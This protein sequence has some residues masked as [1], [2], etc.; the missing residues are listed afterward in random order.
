MNLAANTLKTLK[1][2]PNQKDDGPLLKKQRVDSGSD[3]TNYPTDI[4]NHNYIDDREDGNFDLW[5]KSTTY[6]KY[7]PSSISRPIVIGNAQM[8][9]N[10]A[11]ITSVDQSINLEAIAEK[12]LV[13]ITRVLASAVTSTTKQETD[14]A[15]LLLYELRKDEIKRREAE[16]GKKAK[17]EED[18]KAA[19]KEERER[20]AKEKQEGKERKA[21][22]EK[23]EYERKVKAK[24]EERERKEQ[25]EKE[26]YKR[27]VKAKQE[28]NE[29]KAQEQQDQWAADKEK[30][31]RQAKENESARRDR[32]KNDQMANNFQLARMKLLLGSFI[33]F[34][35]TCSIIIPQTKEVLIEMFK[36]WYEF[37][38]YLVKE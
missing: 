12:I 10:Y 30:R 32:Q 31:E 6:P 33:V 1:Q 27:K 25:Q 16:E 34:C 23:E 18:K 9:R 17:E 11:S 24:K 15:K 5:Q 37:L 21:Q 35:I 22:Q 8:N 19:D 13:P 14:E 4:D 2:P 36:G 38:K 3:E 29:R 26:D 28:E 20:K 7:T